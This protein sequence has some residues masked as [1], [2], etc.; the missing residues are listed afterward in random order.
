MSTHTHIDQLSE[1]KFILNQN[2]QILTIHTCHQIACSIINYEYLLF[3][4]FAENKRLCNNVL[5]CVSKTITVEK[6]ECDN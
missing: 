5:K 3:K 1:T 6:K 2:L 4:I